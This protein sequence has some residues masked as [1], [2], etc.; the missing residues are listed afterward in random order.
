MSLQKET[1]PCPTKGCRTVCLSLNGLRRHVNAGSHDIPAETRTFTDKAIIQLSTMVETS[2]QARILT[3]DDGLN[4]SLVQSKSPGLK[5]FRKLVRKVN[6]RLASWMGAT[7][8]DYEV[9]E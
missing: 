2:S 9:E 4:D 3:A 7:R 1:Y 5:Q 8:S 6:L